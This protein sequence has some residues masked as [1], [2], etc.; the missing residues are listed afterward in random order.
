MISNPKVLISILN[1]N[2]PEST[3][4][5]VQSVL[6]SEYDNY[7]ILLL[8]ND[9]TDNSVS[10]LGNSFPDIQLIKMR[11]NLGYAGAHKVSA[12]V[13]LKEK[14][15]LLWILNND[16]EVFPS[17]LKELVNAFVRNGNCL[18]G[19]VSLNSDGLTINS[20]GGLEM[21]DE[22]T[23]DEISGDNIFGGKKINEIEM[24]ERLVSGVQGS[25]F[26]IPTTIIK[27][28]GFMKT[29]FFL[30]AEELE[31]S[32]RLR[33]KYN[34]QTIIVPSSKVIHHVSGS[35]KLNIKL[36]WIKIYYMTRNNN[37]VLKVHF[38]NYDKTPMKIKR[39]PYY[40][41]FFFKHFFITPRN[42][43]DFNY[44][45][46][47][48]TELGNFHSCLNIKGKFLAPENFLD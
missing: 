5:T 7:K 35:F 18:L 32:Y 2:A 14:Y 8:D 16:V 27:E 13:A 21:I 6:L 37:L 30:Y 23:P 25:S 4:N 9:S 11:T 22:I 42:K 19:G 40:C 31:Y 10:F 12:Q 41:K 34:V 43:R 33:L 28:Y 26:M 24:K 48:Y 45:T 1:W 39:L 17:S 47:Y 44:W 20:G 36:S 3:F 46:N 29:H 15:D 38:K